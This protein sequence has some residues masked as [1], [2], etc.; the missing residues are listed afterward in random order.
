MSVA[1][2]IDSSFILSIKLMNKLILQIH[3]LKRVC[4]C[5]KSQ[6]YWTNRNFYKG[7]T[8]GPDFLY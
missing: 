8:F 3:E 1:Y 6:I 2:I 5:A 4:L 7:I